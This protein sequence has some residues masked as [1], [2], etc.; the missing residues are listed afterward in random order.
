MNIHKIQEHDY[1]QR[2]DEDFPDEERLLLHKIT[3]VR[4]I[5]CPVCGVEFRS[6][7]GR[8]VHIRQNHR[9]DQSIKCRGCPLTFKTA[10]GLMQH[11]ESNGC[12]RISQSRLIQQ[13]QTRLMIA[14]VLDGDRH[15]HLEDLDDNDGGVMLDGTPLKSPIL[16][17]VTPGWDPSEFLNMTRT[18]YVCQCRVSYRRVE[19]FE[20]HVI[21]EMRNKK[22]L[23]CPSCFRNFKCSADLV[24]HMEAGSSGCSVAAGSAYGQVLD[25]LTGG[26]V[27]VAGQLHDGSIKYEAGNVEPLYEADTEPTLMGVDVSYANIMW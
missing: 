11:V 17:K 15:I 26:V 19:D 4:H 7:G 8:D 20:E 27:R 25:Q 18:R 14:E 1:C 5:V 6:T 2:C 23:R 9:A 16:R 12:R 10:S 13:Q 22:P 3:S 21:E 24:A